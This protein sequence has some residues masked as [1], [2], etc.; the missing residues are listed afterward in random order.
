MHYWGDVTVQSVKLALVF[1]ADSNSSIPEPLQNAS[2]ELPTEAAGKELHNH[3]A[4][5][6]DNDTESTA[7]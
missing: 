2:A 5:D 3:L 7:L 4:L 1:C 6:I